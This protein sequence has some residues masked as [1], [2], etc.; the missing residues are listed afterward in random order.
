MTAVRSRALADVN[1]LALVRIELDQPREAAGDRP[2][3][4]R[5]LHRGQMLGR[6]PLQVVEDAR[7]VRAAMNA[8]RDE[9][10]KL[11]G[12]LLDDADVDA[13]DIVLVGRLAAEGVD[14]RR[15]LRTGDDLGHRVLA[16]LEQLE[17]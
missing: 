11:R 14:E 1:D 16:V 3:L 15:V 9:A 2:K 6:L 4:R 5:A 13:H 8:R 17:A 7:A 12:D 10:G